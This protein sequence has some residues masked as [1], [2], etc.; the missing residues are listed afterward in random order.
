MIKASNIKITS[1]E[2]GQCKLK[3]EIKIFSKFFDNNK[4]L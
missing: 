3:A 1:G 2:T 4:F